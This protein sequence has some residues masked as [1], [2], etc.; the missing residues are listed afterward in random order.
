[1][2]L[3]Q[4]LKRAPRGEASRLAVALDV[5][6]STITRLASGKRPCSDS[7]ALAIYLETDGEV[8]PGSFPEVAKRIAAAREL[9]SK[10]KKI[11]ARN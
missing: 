3:A 10:M 4:Y 8:Q 7:L 1:M 5:N 9:A 2:N 6:R 11:G